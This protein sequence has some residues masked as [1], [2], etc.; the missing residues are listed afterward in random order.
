MKIPAEM[1]GRSWRPLVSGG[2]PPA[3]W[4][5]SFFYSYFREGRSA[6]PTVNAVRTDSAKLIKYP[7][8]DDWTELFDLAHDPYEQHNLIADANTSDLRR[9]MEQ[10]YDRQAKAVAYAVPDFA[11]EKRLPAAA[12]PLA[13]WVVDLQA[14]HSDAKHAVDDSRYKNDGALK[15]VKLSETGDGAKAWQF[16][17]QGSIDV[18]KSAS[19]DPSSGAFVL[20]STFTATA[21]AGIVVAR[22][23]AS[24][25][26]CLYLEDGKPTF[27]YLSPAGKTLIA[28]SRSI[29]N[30][31][32]TVTA[33]VTANKRI[34]LE[35]DG[36]QVA[37]RKIGDFIDQDPSDRLS[38]GN[39]LGSR[40]A[41]ASLPAFQGRIESVR[42]YSG[43]LQE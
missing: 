12:Q 40:V 3:D 36:K 41:E 25:G 35:V 24:R 22:G 26:Y 16:D 39:D 6:A 34:V 32:T 19:L 5:T 33:R 9:N 21:D 18:P 2:S 38:I 1:Q 4:R 13:A 7:G 31:R 8:H 23:G 30:R 29:T 28:G 37:K 10:E 43:E 27:V 15:G 42:L 20:Q 17:G 11:D 14:G